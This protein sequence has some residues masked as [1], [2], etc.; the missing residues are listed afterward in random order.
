MQGVWVRSL[1][2]ELI[3]HMPHDQKKKKKKKTQN[4]KPKQN[5]NKLKKPQNGPHRKIFK[6]ER[7]TAFKSWHR[8]VQYS[9]ML[10]ESYKQKQYCNK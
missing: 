8:S 7:N 3:S 4:I 5:C 1:L 6:K 10:G 2:R 9:F